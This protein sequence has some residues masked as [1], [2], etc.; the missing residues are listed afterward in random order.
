MSAVVDHGYCELDRAFCQL[1]VTEDPVADLFT[2]ALTTRVMARAT[3]RT[4]MT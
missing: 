2:M 4:C 3:T 1:P